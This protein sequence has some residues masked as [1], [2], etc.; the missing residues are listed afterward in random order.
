M[1]FYS[2]KT[3]SII[4]T[5]QI[6]F[7]NFEKVFKFHKIN[8]KHLIIVNNSPEISLDSFKSPHVT[9]INNSCNI[10]LAAALNIGIL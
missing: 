9:I 5:Y 7:N 8:F 1:N 10:G 4:I 2:E 3:Y 6:K